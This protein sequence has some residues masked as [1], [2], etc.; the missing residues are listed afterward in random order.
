MQSLC[1][2]WAI[3]KYNMNNMSIR[4]FHL[5]TRISLQRIKHCPERW[6]NIELT[7]CEKD[8][9]WRYDYIAV[10]SV[11]ERCGENCQ[12]PSVPLP[13]RRWPWLMTIIWW[14]NI[15]RKND[16]VY[17]LFQKSTDSNPTNPNTNSNSH[18]NLRN[19]GP[20]EY[21]AP[22]PK[23]TTACEEVN[24]RRVVVC[25]RSRC[26][27][28]WYKAAAGQ[29]TTCLSQTRGNITTTQSASVAES[30]HP[31]CTRNYCFQYWPT[32]YSEGHSKD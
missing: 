25:S 4:W 21:S 19:S 20:S 32:I 3:L 10:F 22:V 28:N 9:F 6:N 1:N 15:H 31:V 17:T 18:P 11:P 2:M 30:V 29:L 12:L 16:C 7:W 27:A 8:N 23:G 14:T 24:C 13:Q 26:A 5:F